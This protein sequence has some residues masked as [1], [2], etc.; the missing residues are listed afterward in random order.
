[1]DQP[2]EEEWRHFELYEKIRIRDQRRRFWT[3]LSAGF[4]FLALCAVP[5][6]QERLPKWRSLDA[7]RQLSLELEHLKT[8]AIQ[9]KKPMRM[10]FSDSGMFRVEQVSD[11]SAGGV[12][13]LEQEA[14]W[15]HHENELRVLTKE[16]LARFSLAQG[17]SQVC[18][19]PVYG[20]PDVK[21]RLVLV[22]APVKDLADERLD[23]ASYVILEGESAKIS[24]N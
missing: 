15:S 9:E 1:M 16:E 14:A 20:L 10:T 19:D 8:R 21:G 3:L 7:A 22:I 4:L 13:R 6:I 11:C 12:E 18:F 2:L 23:R 17:V 5:V 24:I